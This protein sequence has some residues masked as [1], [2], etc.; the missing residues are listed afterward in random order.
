M[1]QGRFLLRREGFTLIEM[2]VALAVF[3]LATT[4]LLKL[5]T[6]STRT[7]AAVEQKTLGGMVADTV[8]AQIALGREGASSGQ[9][10][11]AG[12]LWHWTSAAVPLEGALQAFE[13]SVVVQGQL[14]AQRRLYRQVGPAALGAQ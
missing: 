13:V 4:A 9:I 7:T 12:Q 3:A 1:V 14:I 5:A 2:L 6:E 11:M 8:A 10:E